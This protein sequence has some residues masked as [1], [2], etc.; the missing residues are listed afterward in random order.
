MAGR[1]VVPSAGLLTAALA[2]DAAGSLPLALVHSTVQAAARFAAIRAA[3]TSAV[4]SAQAIVLCQG[5]L[6]T[7]LWTQLK[8]I[9]AIVLVAGTLLATGAGVAGRLCRKTSGRRPAR[10]APDDRPDRVQVV[11]SLSFDNY[12]LVPGETTILSILPAN[13]RVKKGQLVCE[14]DPA[15]SQGPAGQPE[16]DDPSGRVRLPQCQVDAQGCRTG[17]HRVHGRYLQARCGDRP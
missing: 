9:A 16:D 11:R 8:T 10:P 2:H 12:N 7:M 14:L 15:R 6:H 3:T 17:W 1:G 5:V 13:V 4:I